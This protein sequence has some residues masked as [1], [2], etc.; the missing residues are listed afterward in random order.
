ML[1]KKKKTQ[2]TQRNAIFFISEKKV[3]LKLKKL[4]NKYNYYILFVV[5]NFFFFYNQTEIYI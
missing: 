1:E 5:F 3:F 4:K 2:K